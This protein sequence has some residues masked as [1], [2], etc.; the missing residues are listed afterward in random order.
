MRHY[1]NVNEYQGVDPWWFSLKQDNDSSAV[2]F[3]LRNEKDLRIG[4]VHL[5]SNRQYVHCTGDKCPYCAIGN[6]AK[7]R[8]FIPVYDIEAKQLKFQD[9]SP[10]CLHSLVPIFKTWSNATDAIFRII[11][12]GEPYDIGTKYGMYVVA[13]NTV[14]SHRAIYDEWKD[15]IPDFFQGILPDPDKESGE[16]DEPEEIAPEAVKQLTSLSC[17][18][19]GGAIDRATMTCKFCGTYHILPALLA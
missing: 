15:K 6:K 10:L 19:C 16:Y 3:V 9:R 1:V 13:D 4:N 7:A 17:N 2:I 18:C 11:R 14:I 12:H 5:L 8:V